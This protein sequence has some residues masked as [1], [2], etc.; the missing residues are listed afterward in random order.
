MIPALLALTGEALPIPPTQGDQVTLSIDES[1]RYVL[2]AKPL[3]FLGQRRIAPAI[4]PQVQMAL[5]PSTVLARP[6]ETAGWTVRLRNDFGT[7]V[8]I[9]LSTAH[10]WDGERPQARL[11]LGA[12][13]AAEVPMSVEVTATAKGGIVSWDITCRYEPGEDRWPAAEFRR[14]IYFV[15][16]KRP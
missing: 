6:G 10:P 16:P 2:S 1:V 3:R 4:A 11:V 15:V 5:A 8:T 7:P 9:A 14:A 13:A 12:L